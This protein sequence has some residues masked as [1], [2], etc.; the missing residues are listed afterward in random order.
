MHTCV[1]EA[2]CCI[3]S[4]PVSVKVVVVEWFLTLIPSEYFVAF[5]V[6]ARERE[7]ERE[8]GGGGR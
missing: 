5:C 7:R 3:A 1:V 6:R 2:E 8:R 4:L